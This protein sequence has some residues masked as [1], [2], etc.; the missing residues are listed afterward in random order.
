ML[1]VS[2]DFLAGDDVTLETTDGSCFARGLVNDGSS[3]LDR[4]LGVKTVRVLDILGVCACVEVI[5]RYDFVV[6][7]REEP[8]S[9]SHPPLTQ[10][11][12]N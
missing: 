10:E 1:A 5:H 7:C 3:E 9:R 2:R 12:R 11:S 4:L 8:T 6:I